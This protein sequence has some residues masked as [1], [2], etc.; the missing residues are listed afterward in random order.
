MKKISNTNPKELQIQIIYDSRKIAELRLKQ[1]DVKCSAEI[2][3]I[4]A[5]LNHSQ[6]RG[7]SIG[8]RSVWMLRHK[9]SYRN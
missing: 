7:E 1:Q 2:N 4:K 9:K 3:Q 5:S 6:F 8:I